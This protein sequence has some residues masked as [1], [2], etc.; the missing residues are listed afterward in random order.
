MNDEGKID[1][2][3]VE[4]LSIVHVE[5]DLG[6]INVADMGE[7]D[8]GEAAWLISRKGSDTWN[9]DQHKLDKRSVQWSQ[10]R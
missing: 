1:I 10:S 7:K 3:E 9:K 5:G 6:L 8:P 4:G 2:A